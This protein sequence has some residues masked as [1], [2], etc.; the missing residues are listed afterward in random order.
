[1]RD[2]FYCLSE[3][4]VDSFAGGGG[5]STGIE[6][7]LGTRVDV[8]IDHDPEALTMHARNHPRSAH[9]CEDVWAVDPE[10]VCRGKPVGLMW[11]SPDCKH[12]SHA[13]GGKPVEKKIRG[14]AWIAVRWARAVRPRVI[15]L[16]NV[17]E[18]RDWGPLGEDGRPDPL[19]KGL[20]F[21]RF[22]GSLRN[23]GYTCDM[24]SLRACDFGAP[25]TRKRLFLVARCDGQPIVWP[26]PTH[27]GILRPYNSAAGCIDFSLPCPSIF[28]RERPLVHNTLRRIAAGTKRYVID[29]E[30]PFIVPL[31]HHGAGGIKHAVVAAFLAKHNGIGPKMVVGQGL[32]E[33][34]HTIP[35]I[36]QKAIVTNTLAPASAGLE[37][38]RQVYAFLMKFYSKGGQW[39]SL[40]DPMHT[41]PAKDRMALVMVHGE[42]HVIADIGMRML[43]PR[44]LFNAQGFPGSYDIEA[45]GLLSKT[46]QVRMVGNSVSPPLAQALVRANLIEAAQRIGLK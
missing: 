22:V 34:V 1:M 12:F 15:I 29:C 41:I 5:A 31:T 6:A 14:L 26:E 24:R 20:T 36:D 28:D 2:E 38:A 13:R 25:T 18:F 9:Y 3:L 40:L 35:A 11:L 45:D 37:R 10:D 30:R 21:R 39:S 16:E 19:R 43:T 17:E 7:A 46:A 33:P 23:L 44:E 32:N 8:A 42:P 4:I 27:G